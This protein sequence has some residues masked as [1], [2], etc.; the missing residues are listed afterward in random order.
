MWTCC[1]WKFQCSPQCLL[2][3][4]KWDE[5]IS[6]GS[7]GN[8]VFLWNSKTTSRQRPN[9]PVDQPDKLL[10]R[11]YF[12][13]PAWVQQCV[14]VMALLLG[15]RDGSHQDNAIFQ[16]LIAFTMQNPLRL[17]F[18]SLSLVSVP[19]HMNMCGLRG[20]LI[21]CFDHYTSSL[22]TERLN[23]VGRNL[24]TYR[25]GT[26]FQQNMHHPHFIVPYL[27]HHV[28]VCLD[29]GSSHLKITS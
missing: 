23:Y 14:V 27:P 8:I 20:G 15:G 2:R 18:R 12:V 10:W 28:N 25:T 29:N 22:R 17:D 5:P 26:S 6:R 11:L 19:G 1:W 21:F 4:K 13:I 16:S 9:H 24:H 3:Q 7:Q